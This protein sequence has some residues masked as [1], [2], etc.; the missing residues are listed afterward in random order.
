MRLSTSEE[1]GLRTV[2]IIGL[3]LKGIGG[4]V[5]AATGVLLFFVRQTT[6]VKLAGFLTQ[7][8]LREEPN[9]LIA[10][11]VNNFAKHLSLDIKTFGAFYL[12]AHGAINILLVA[13]LLRNKR[14]AYPSA[15]VFLGIFLIY[16]T[17][18]LAFLSFSLWLLA[19]TI[20]DVFIFVLIW[21]E[22]KRFGKPA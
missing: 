15:L 11:A 1:K 7:G 20:F 4:I 3:V 12:L 17:Y 21:H 6:I 16:Q 14:W 2:F 18:R 5:E 22:W 9:D 19:L 8:E 13:G 10:N